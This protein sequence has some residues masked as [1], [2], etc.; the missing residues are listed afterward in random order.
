VAGQP[1]VD[2]GISQI[3]VRMMPGSLGGGTDG[4][5]QRQPSREVASGDPG[6]K[7]HAQISPTVQ[8]GVRDLLPG[9]SRHDI[10]S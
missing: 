2:V 10:K 3:D 5:D 8:A 9:K 1:D 7:A 6:L 4:G